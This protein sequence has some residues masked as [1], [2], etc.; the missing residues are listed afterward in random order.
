M[1]AMR[2]VPHLPSDM[3]ASLAREAS[4][5]LSR[6]R[7]AEEAVKVTIDGQQGRIEAT[8]P[9]FAFE[10]LLDMLTQMAQGKAVTIIP[11]NA[12]LTTQQAA[13]LL[14]VSRPFLIKLIEEGK[15]TCR[16]VG[17]HRRIRFD[18]LMN[19]KDKMDG[20]RIETLDELTRASQELG[21]E[22]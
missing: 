16:K 22:Y 3:E 1:V 12:E 20:E 4:R 9:A 6:V 19:L 7:P 14:N 10:M 2:G 21:V 17:R 5:L 8:M 13:D 11:H 18:E 15:L